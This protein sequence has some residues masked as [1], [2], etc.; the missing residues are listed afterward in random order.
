MNKLFSEL[1]VGDRFTSNGQEYIKIQDVRVSCC[2]SVNCHSVGN[3]NSK[4]FIH[5]ST[6][7]TV[8]A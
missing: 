4:S 6:M 8:N 5:P 2:R 3:V 1:A 7:V